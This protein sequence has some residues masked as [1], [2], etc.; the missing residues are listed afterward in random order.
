MMCARCDQPILKG[1]AYDTQDVER[2]SGPPVTVTVHK[3]QCRRV[4]QPTVQQ[5]RGARAR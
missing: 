4:D 5:G 2:A 3:E 1:Q